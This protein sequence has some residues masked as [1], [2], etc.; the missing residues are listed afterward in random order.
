M[1]DGER[2]GLA[3]ARRLGA[4]FDHRPEARHPAL[5]NVRSQGIV[6]LV[7][8]QGSPLLVAAET[9]AGFGQ[10]LDQSPEPGRTRW[11]LLGQS[12][13][14]MVPVPSPPPQHMVMSA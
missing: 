12:R 6:E 5:V 2:G 9:D 3:P 10:L 4:R 7:K 1:G 14:M 13:S 8:E 11:K